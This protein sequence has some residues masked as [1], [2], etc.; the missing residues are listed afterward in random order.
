MIGQLK[1]KQIQLK[2]IYI[3]AKLPEPLQPLKELAN[4]LWWSWS[5]SAIELF[6]SIDREQFISLRYNPV[7]L[8]EELSPARAQELAADSSFIQQLNSVYAEFQ[9]YLS[10]EPAADSPQIAYFSMEYGLHIS[11]RLYSGGLGVLAGDYLKEASDSNSNMVAVGLLYRYGYF[12]QAISLHGDQINNYPPQKFTKLPIRPVR[13]AQGEWLKISVGLKGRMVYAKIWELKVGRI[14]LYL[15]DT[16]IDENDWH[17][18]TLTHQLYGGDN[19][20]RLRQEILLGIGGAR[21]LQALGVEADIYHC[22]EGHAAFLNLERLRGYVREQ[23]LSYAAAVEAVRATSLFTTHTPVPAGHDYFHE[24]LLRDYLYNYALELGIDWQTFVALGKIDPHNHD[25][26]FS[27]SHLAIRLSQEVNGV[28]RLH[29]AVSQKMFNVLYPGYNPE[30]LHIH[31]VTNS[32]HYPTWIAKEW[33]DLYVETFGEA[34]LKDQSNKAYWRKIYDVP[35]EQIMG[36]RRKLKARLLGYVRDTLQEDLTRRGENPRSIFELLNA[37]QEDALVI[38]FARRFATYKRAHLLFSNLDRLASILNNSGRP[39]IFLFAGKAHPADGGGQGLIK[40]IIEVSKR[41][42]FKGKVIFLENYNMEMAKLLVQGVDIWLNTPT[43]PKEASGTSGMK[44][45]LNGVM[46]F[47]VL[48]GW[49][50]EGFRPD[51]GWEL[52]LERTY[53]NQ[54]LQNEL[55]AET[56]YNT[57]EHD[58]LPKY[59]DVDET[60]IS[61]RWV[62]YIRA[63]IAEVAP[64]FTMKRMLDD[65]YSRFYNKLYERGQLA[66]QNGCKQA[67]AIAAW[68]QNMKQ[69]WDHIELAQADT[70]D[71]D[72]QALQTGEAFKATLRIYLNGVQPEDLGVEVAF[73]SRVNEE[74]LELKFTQELELK[75]VRDGLAEFTCTV[76]PKL[77]GVFE[78]GFRAFPKSEQLAHRQDLP[79]VKWL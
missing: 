22:N 13:D 29:G 25:E 26:L 24:N 71:S 61:E 60:G 78:Y 70:F 74:E 37:I 42:E 40:H 7:A 4:N 1:D 47:S 76:D 23:Q 15:M 54:E 2:R 6:E 49:W 35:A 43:R 28:S 18:R 51:A 14:S 16:D 41:P 32:V 33:H 58:I 72:N 11:L 68:K 62:A 57:L 9:S 73:F 63:I 27:M 38:G 64:E 5:K 53:D 59:Y 10:E 56:I 69:R 55:D 52:P 66:R 46:N 48:D 19:E 17:D 8:L 67:K 77:A 20:H 75:A 39:L 45:A 36:I 12:E 3:E 34:F 79:L 21:A 65:Y 31:Y 30:E 44:A 50:A